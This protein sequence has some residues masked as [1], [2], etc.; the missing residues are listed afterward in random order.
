MK[1]LSAI[2]IAAALVSSRGGAQPPAEVGTWSPGWSAPYCTISTGDPK[3][4][5]LSIW[6]VPGSGGVEIYFMGNSRQVPDIGSTAPNPG[7][8][9]LAQISEM[10]SNREALAQMGDGR[11]PIPVT[12]LWTAPS[13]TGVLEFAMTGEDFVGNFGNS[14]ELF[15]RQQNKLVGMHY[16]GARE[17]MNALQHCID[18]KLREWGVDSAALRSLRRYPIL[19][20]DSWVSYQDYPKDALAQKQGGTVVVRLTANESG[21]VTNCAVVLSSGVKSLDDVTCRIALRRARY[22][23]AVGANG[24][25]TSATFINYAKFD[26][27]P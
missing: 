2:A 7:L 16:N 4:L 25:R 13:S 17:A 10:A 1:S 9:P 14:T 20:L 24:R 26:V 23:P 21:K 18:A 3:E 12:V 15:V 8:G 6:Q 22:K 5:A 11:Q 27:L 19:R